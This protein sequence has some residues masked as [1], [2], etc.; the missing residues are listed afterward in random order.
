MAPMKLVTHREPD[1]VHDQSKCPLG[2]LD[3]R[4]RC[5]LFPVIREVLCYAVLQHLLPMH[6]R[7]WKCPLRKQDRFKLHF[8][9][10]GEL[11]TCRF[12]HNIIIRLC[13]MGEVRC[14]NHIN[15]RGMFCGLGVLFSKEVMV[16]EVS[17][18]RK[19]PRT[20]PVWTNQA[21]PALHIAR[22]AQSDRASDS[23]ML[24]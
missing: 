13:K 11:S 12:I 16:E 22:L 17:S 4:Y 15:P 9:L 5:T 10:G 24:R 21:K 14:R 8:D 1:L 2:S 20:V 6:L 18:S 19:T 23:Y 3:E 7:E